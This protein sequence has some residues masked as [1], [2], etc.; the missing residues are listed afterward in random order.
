MGGKWGK[1]AVG[2]DTHVNDLLV[3][4][5]TPAKGPVEGLH[6]TVTG[7]E[8]HGTNV[9]VLA[10]FMV[11]FGEHGEGGGVAELVKD[12]LQDLVCRVGQ[13]R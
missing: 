7:E 9:G 3:Q 10:E 2:E 6:A 11:A 8:V 5:F 4:E 1:V 12:E 13:R